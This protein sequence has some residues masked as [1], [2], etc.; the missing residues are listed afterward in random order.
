[1]SALSNFRES[2]SLALK[3]F[4]G[5]VLSCLGVA[6]ALTYA[7]H[8]PQAAGALGFTQRL[9][10]AAALGVPLCFALRILRECNKPRIGAWIEW[11]PL[12]AIAF[13]YWA[14]PASG[15]DSPGS[16][17]LR[18]LLTLAGLHFAVAV[19][20]F[21]SQS[22]ENRFWQF[23]WR[24][25]L[26]FCTASFY[27]AVLTAG[28]ELAL[29]SADKLFNLELRHA[30]QDLFN[31]MAFLVHPLFFLTGVPRHV[32]A[33]E[34]ETTYP[35]AL[36]SFTQFVLAPLAAVFTAILYVYAAKIC[37]HR[38]W[39]QG[40]VALPVLSLSAVGVLA[41][42]L[43]HPLFSDQDER[44]ARW[45]KTYFPRLLAP[46]AV[47]LLLALRERINAYGVTE[48]RYLGCLAGFWILLWSLGYSIKPGAGIRWIPASLLVLC[49]ASAFG[50]WSASALS[51]NDQ[52]ERLRG[53]LD[54]L[55]LHPT[56]GA[57]DFEKKHPLPSKDYTNLRKT[58]QYLAERHGAQT[59][60]PLFPGVFTDNENDKGRPS[61]W[62]TTNTAMNALGVIDAGSSSFNYLHFE[63]AKSEGISVEGFSKIVIFPEV[64]SV[65][66][67]L[68]KMTKGGL[69]V[70]YAQ[71]ELR[72]GF[73]DSSPSLRIPLSELLQSL[74][75]A[76]NPDL[77][78]GDLQ[79]DWQQEGRQF[80]ILF[81]SLDLTYSGTA[82]PS[83]R[84]CS[85][86]VLEK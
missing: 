19:G 70:H 6:L 23:N 38:S 29:L 59:L 20:A 12:P 54:T 49:A 32:E 74:P 22:S 39:P 21:I 77:K 62:N 66:K 7:I 85:F 43:L 63:L 2:L 9:A 57:K 14:L 35:R 61:S 11:T 10:M 71:E 17:T 67:I 34:N 47:L 73:S 41:T 50:P 84:G 80:R 33:L 40:W 48:E 76:S 86:V 15:F 44:W 8:K 60:H 3:R 83:I 26:Q 30:Y 64:K 37:V 13:A 46:L 81:T 42:L 79:A 52:T 69:C 4:P 45:F 75:K 5:V 51:L 68:S 82:S 24:I 55:N 27:G 36:K 53:I 18:W 65:P 58:I 31:F 78:C 16:V 56:P 28:M 72:L 25:F 1:V